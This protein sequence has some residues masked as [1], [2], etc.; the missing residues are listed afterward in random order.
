MVIVWKK[1][2]NGIANYETF[3]KIESIQK[4]WLSDK[5]YYIEMNKGERL[6]LRI[7]DI[8]F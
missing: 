3:T 2:M 4:G 6:L 7:S 8:Y 1:I 5:K